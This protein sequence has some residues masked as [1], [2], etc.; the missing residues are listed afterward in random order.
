MSKEHSKKGV[1]YTC[2]TGNYDDIINHS[3]VNGEWDYVCFTDSIPENKDKYIWEFRQLNFTD[4]DDAKNQRWHKLHP[5]KLFPD[6]TKSI[7]VDGNIEIINEGFFSD[8]ERVS[9]EGERMAISIHPQRD[10]IYEELVAC[11][12]LGKDNKQIMK[13]QVDLI[14][15]RGFPEHHGLFETSVIYREHHDANIASIMEDWWYWIKNYSRRDQ[16]SLTFVLWQHNYSVAPLN[17]KPLRETPYISFNFSERHV[18]K[19]GLIVQKRELSQK[20]EQLK[21]ESAKKDSIIASQN[22]EIQL[23]G[24]EAKRINQ[25][26]QE[27]E[28]VLQEQLLHIQFMESSKFWKLRAWS[29]RIKFAV[30][31]PIKF[32]RKYS[33]I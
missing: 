23:K 24:K 17:K 11:I 15:K 5:H 18:T 7:W 26:L 3:F 22:K 19:E 33:K 28:N 32:F 6:Y 1:I 27:K 25:L 20:L 31:H 16:L 4:L 10:C 21:Q 2:V 13:R 8:I 30:F 14:R 9:K 12:R 29:E